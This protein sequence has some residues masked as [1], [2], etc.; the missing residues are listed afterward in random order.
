[1][2]MIDPCEIK[3]KKK[4]N[5]AYGCYVENGRKEIVWAKGL[6]STKVAN[7]LNRSKR[8][9]V[10]IDGLDIKG[11]LVIKRNNEAIEA[12]VKVVSVLV[13]CSTPLCGGVRTALVVKYEGNPGLF[14]GIADCV[15]TIKPGVVKLVF[16]H[17]HP[18][19][20]EL[21]G[22]EEWRAHVRYEEGIV[23]L[24]SGRGVDVD[25]IKDEPGRITADDEAPKRAG[26]GGGEKEPKKVKAD[27]TNMTLRELLADDRNTI[28]IMKE[29]LHSPMFNTE[30]LPD[31][32][33]AKALITMVETYNLNRPETDKIST[34]KNSKEK[35][36]RFFTDFWFPSKGE[37]GKEME[38]LMIAEVINL[39]QN[40]VRKPIEKKKPTTYEEAL[41]PIKGATVEQLTAYLPMIMG[42]A[43]KTNRNRGPLIDQLVAH[44]KTEKDKQ[45]FLA[46][47]REEKTLDQIQFE[48]K[49]RDEDEDED[50]DIA[51]AYALEKE[52]EQERLERE[53]EAKQE[54]EEKEEEERVRK[55]DEERK[56]EEEESFRKDREE[57]EKLAKMIEE[58]LRLHF[59]EWVIETVSENKNF[60]ISF[61]PIDVARYCDDYFFKH[62]HIS[63]MMSASILDKEGFCRWHG[64]NEDQVCYIHEKSPFNPDKRPI[65]LHTVGSM[66]YKNINKTKPRT[67]P[68]IKDILKKHFLDKG[69]IHTH[70]HKLTQYLMDELSDQRLISYTNIK[71]NSRNKPIREDVIQRLMDSENPLVLVAPSVDEGIDLP[72]DLF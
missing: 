66:A 53:R 12:A 24:V 34:S 25:F 42:T 39:I 72:D 10:D 51:G 4:M 38:K 6:C 1:M 57:E 18:L 7:K 8:T 64:L 71:K 17:T 46:F 59:N 49:G 14:E 35:L 33:W 30:G 44:V 40:K 69:L 68:V 56:R 54:R 23:H 36:A 11:K 16:I 62:A 2:N 50:E 70:N 28:D 9:V 61:K 3:S 32:K 21:A 27:I 13:Q 47:V 37:K 65:H 55:L 19:P 20:H 48:T 22:E 67:I 15:D 58:E 26:E 5:C 45:N 63:L 41:M 52:R 31:D 29:I 60:N 43:Y